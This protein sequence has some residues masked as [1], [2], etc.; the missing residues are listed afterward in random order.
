M[1]ATIE[2]TPESSGPSAAASRSRVADLFWGAATAGPAGVAVG[3]VA[4]TAL[5]MITTTSFAT[6]QNFEVLA[7]GVAVTSMVGL[8]QMVV[9]AAGGLNLSVGATGA[10]VAVVTGA[11][12]NSYGLPSPIATLVGLTAGTLSGALNGIVIVRTGISPFIV[13][14]ASGSIFT[15]IALGVTESVPYYRLPSDFAALGNTSFI[16]I[17]L[18]FVVAIVLAGLLGL[19]FRYLS[20]GRQILAFGANPRAA[21]LA[22]VST[23]RLQVVVYALSGFL[24]SCASILLIARLGSA[25]PTIGFDWLLPSFAVPII[26]GARLAGGSVS[27]LGAVLGAVLLGTLANGLVQWNVSIFYVQL[28]SGL[29]ILAAGGIDR[30][31]QLSGE[32]ALRAERRRA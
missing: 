30:I 3:A 26:G 27:V 12:L 1:I 16:G 6:P 8:A 20:L 24:A 13:T 18:I 22:G 14:L 29:I 32:I 10:L 28:L 2:P 17:P 31:R 7:R 19:V 21:E 25:D 15:G 9:L 5:L 23:G 11:L 4:L